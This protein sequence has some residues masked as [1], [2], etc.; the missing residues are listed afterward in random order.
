MD[1]IR[2]QIEMMTRRHFFGRTT[3]MGLGSVAL[4]SLLAETGHAGGTRR[5]GQAR[6]SR[7]RP[8]AAFRACL[9]S[10]PRRSGRSTCT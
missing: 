7:S 4:A 8:S 9:I 5:P 3:G 10:P 2:E 6:G 1:P